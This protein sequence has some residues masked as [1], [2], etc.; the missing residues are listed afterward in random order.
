MNSAEE[1]RANLARIGQQDVLPGELE[2]HR[3]VEELVDRDV[4]GETLAP[5]SG[6]KHI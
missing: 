1:K 3:V 4:L 2:Q 5:P 6:E